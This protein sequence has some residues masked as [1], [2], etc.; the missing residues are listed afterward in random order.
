MRERPRI[1]ALLV[2]IDGYSSPTIPDLRG[3]V[4]D[5]RAVRAFLVHRLQVPETRIWTLTSSVPQ[6]AGER[7]PTRAHILAAWQEIVQQLRPGDQFFFHYSGH[8]A[9]APS[10]DPDEPDGFDETIVP[11]DSRTTDAAGRPVFD[12]LDKELAALI[13]MAEDRGAQVAAVLDCCHSGSG[14]RAALRPDP[15]RPLARRCRAD[16][17][18]RELAST[19]PGT[20]QHLEAARRLRRSSGWKV[21]GR[22]VLLAAARDEELSYEYRSPETGQWHGAATYFLV[23]ALQGY[24]PDMTWQE[25]YD[26]VRTRVHGIYPQQT[27]Q[28]EGPGNRRIFG[29]EAPPVAPYLRVTEVEAT[30]SGPV[31]QVDGGVAVGLVEG[32]QVAIYPPGSD[33]QGEPLAQG[34]VIRADVDH[35]WVQLPPGL[36]VDAVPL[37]ARARILSLGFETLVYAVAVSDPW[38]RAALQGEPPFQD[39]KP[40][41]FLEVVSHDAPGAHFRVDATPEGYAIQDGSGA[42]IVATMPPR[43]QAG[44]VQVAQHLHHLAVF[45]NVRALR[46]PTPAPLLAHALEVRAYSYTR[47]GFSAPKDGIPLDEVD[48]ILTP[49]RRI[50]VTVRNLSARTLYVAVFN[51][52]SN[53]GIHRIYPPH[54]PHQTVVPGAAFHIPRLRPEIH[55]PSLPAATEVI[56]VFASTVP[57]DFDVL[58]LPDL[59]Q[60]E[61]TAAETR[62]ATGPLAELL[63]G[64][65][66]T[67]TR[68]LV[69]TEDIHD[70][71]ITCQMEI[72]V[73]NEPTRH[74][75][76]AGQRAVELGT[77][78]ELRVE[79]PPEFQGEIVL[80]T[81]LQATRGP[82][83]QHPV[84]PPPALESPEGQRLFSPIAL[85]GTA[86]SA[87]ASPG[88]LAINASPTALETLD[89]DHPLRLELSLD[90]SEELEGVVA[91]AWDGQHHY[92]VGQTTSLSP[93][94]ER[95]GRRRV[96]VTVARLP[97]PADLSAGEPILSARDLPPELAQSPTAGERPHRDLR[98]TVRLF[99]YRIHRREPPPDMGVRRATLDEDGTPVYAP[100]HPEEVAQASRVALLV[101]GLTGDTRWLVQR[102]WPHLQ[103]W[104]AYDLLLA[105]DYE[106][107][108]V[109]IEENGHRLA[110]ALQT[111]GFGPTDGIHLDVFAHGLGT[112]VVRAMV[113]LAGGHAFVD[114][115]FLAG[116]PNAG[117]RLADVKGL[118]FWSAT[119]LLN[120]A[121]VGPVTLIA[122][123]ALKKALDAGVAV[124]DLR[125]GS[126]FYRKLN[127][128]DSPLDVPYFV[129]IGENSRRAKPFPGEV[130]FAKSGVLRL[131]DMGLDRLLGGPNDLVVSVASARAV[132]QG[133]WPQLQVTVLPGHHFQYFQTPESLEALAPIRADSTTFGQSSGPGLE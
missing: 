113:E 41:P 66:H 72:T 45:H 47:A 125:P 131:V 74:P 12:L 17:R 46:N 40:S 33:L 39:R 61:A 29:E 97:L 122:E 15:T 95:T 129:Q 88:I 19:V 108:T 111:L 71:W 132:R 57:M 121:G 13:A 117:T 106:S 69:V 7:L 51:L 118:A 82:D 5:V 49:G 65:R 70:R 43:T 36:P 110:Q 93:P 98:R 75:L 64:V 56:K 20:A 127:E 2:G 44:A 67:G 94:D 1:F 31:V 8:G 124:D 81:L 52:S 34:S 91:V 102:L 87:G 4:A 18:P 76:P 86:R 68:K 120:Q 16:H 73:L 59:N 38:V 11:M 42:Q 35:A 54:A 112:Q 101:H 21:P 14:T 23:Q 130:L 99:L 79:K 58:Q 25:V 119:L 55:H 123:W 109:P 80:S 104:A 63:E 10:V 6:V 60:P 85:E 83:V 78:L 32:S 30:P 105:F 92:L 27:P 128:A 22:H 126:E 62:R 103:K 26:V 107:L 24:R 89:P 9:Q 28:L 100:I 133:R 84:T 77:P 114:R 3:C 96:T 50:W 115:A 48:H 37:P 53:F 116:P 90:A